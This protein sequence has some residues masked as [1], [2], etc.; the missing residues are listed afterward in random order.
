MLIFLDCTDHTAH[1][2][3][4]VLDCLDAYGVPDGVACA[5]DG[6]WRKRLK[7]V[8]K[9][10]AVK[11]ELQEYDVEIRCG[12]DHLKYEEYNQDDHQEHDEQG[13]HETPLQKLQRVVRR[14]RNYQKCVV[15]G[16][17]GLGLRSMEA[18]CGG[19]AGLRCKNHGGR[20]PCAAKDCALYG[21]RSVMSHNGKLE[22]FCNR[23]GQQ[24]CMPDCTRAGVRKIYQ[25]KP[26]GWRCRVHGGAKR[27]DVEGCSNRC[28]RSV[29]TEDE[30]GPP[31]GRCGKHGRKCS[32]KKCSKIGHRRVTDDDQFG[33]AGYRCLK[34]G[35]GHPCSI[36]RCTNI[37]LNKKHPFGDRL[38]PAGWRCDKHMRPCVAD[39]C[40]A[41]GR[42]LTQTA[43]QYGPAGYRC[44]KHRQV[45]SEITEPP[46]LA[47]PPH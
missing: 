35:G 2:L 39:G 9:K 15:S 8:G 4:P 44:Y 41:R 46:P 18:D 7:R 1:V 17:T 32:A 6:D 45:E 21:I 25:T 43:D 27:C 30:H 37:A 26:Y 33:R 42:K 31:G 34:H 5:F 14:K 47:D 10:C 40:T 12:T 22:R 28:E 36:E 16:C 29:A 20:F 23:H 3:G 11:E 24:C 38:G 13:E 19:A